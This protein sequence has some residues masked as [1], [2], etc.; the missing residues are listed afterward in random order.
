LKVQVNAP[1][2]TNSFWNDVIGKGC[3]TFDQL[4]I[5]M[6]AVA[7]QIRVGVSVAGLYQIPPPTNNPKGSI[8]K[9]QEH[10]IDISNAH[11]NK[12]LNIHTPT[13]SQRHPRVLQLLFDS[14]ADALSRQ[15][16]ITEATVTERLCLLEDDELYVP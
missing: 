15:S 5:A 1:L 10:V 14:V 4:L 6:T 8:G 12:R 13:A 2:A 9:R 11:G 16:P 3:E 7:N